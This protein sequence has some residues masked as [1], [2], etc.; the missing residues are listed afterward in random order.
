M[1]LGA[2]LPREGSHLAL[3]FADRRGAEGRPPF[4]AAPVV[5]RHHDT[6]QR[7]GFPKFAPVV[8]SI[9]EQ[10][11]DH[12]AFDYHPRP[13]LACSAQQVGDVAQVAW[14]AIQ[15]VLTSPDRDNRRV[16]TTS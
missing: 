1:V 4:E 9:G 2:A 8:G 13:R 11:I 3:H 5:R 16:M 12:L 14:R 7:R 6:D 10:G 15:E